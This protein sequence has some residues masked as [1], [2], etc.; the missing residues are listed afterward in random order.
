MFKAEIG[1]ISFLNFFPFF[2]L[3]LIFY[4]SAKNWIGPNMP[5]R[6]VAYIENDDIDKI[7]Y[8]YCGVQNNKIQTSHSH[9]NDWVTITE[10]QSNAEA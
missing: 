6:P 4:Q 3:H 10:I 9:L 1:G 5:S 7:V 8:Y 2:Y